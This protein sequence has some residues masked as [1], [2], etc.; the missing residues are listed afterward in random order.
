MK[1]VVL[2]IAFLCTPSMAGELIYTPVNPAFGGSPLNGAWMQSSASAQNTFKDPNAPGNK[3]QTP[4]QRFNERLQNSILDR[5]A[6]AITKEVVD[7]N[8][9]LKPG[10]IDTGGFRVTVLDNGDGTVTIIT[11][12]KSTGE[13]SRFDILQTNSLI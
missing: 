2:N 12:D 9:D 6:N 7:E 3:T 10:V 4:L 5:V 11:L 8:G 13:T 1:W